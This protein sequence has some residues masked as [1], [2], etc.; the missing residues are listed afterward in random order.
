MNNFGQGVGSA[1][2][3][4]SV[5]AAELL[6]RE[7]DREVHAFGLVGGTFVPLVGV[8]PL[9]AKQEKLAQAACVV[10]EAREVFATVRA[11]MNAPGEMVT[12]L[13]AIPLH[14]PP[15][16]DE[17]VCVPYTVDLVPGPM[18]IAALSHQ[19]LEQLKACGLGNS[20]TLFAWRSEYTRASVVLVVRQDEAREAFSNY[21]SWLTS[22]LGA[23]QGKSFKAVK[24][25]LSL[26]AVELSVVE[27][28]V[29]EVRAEAA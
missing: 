28:N 7:F 18:G 12:F 16:A 13:T 24:E 3:F 6:P 8:W 22:T 1:V 9:P 25:V 23:E 20:A 15:C 19:L 2:A 29:A 21:V 5:T 10:E 11:M 4:V 14:F 17:V 26:P 27:E